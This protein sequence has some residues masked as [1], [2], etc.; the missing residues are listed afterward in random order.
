MFQATHFQ[1]D[2]VF[3]GMLVFAFLAFGAVRYAAR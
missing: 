1:L 3:G 2:H